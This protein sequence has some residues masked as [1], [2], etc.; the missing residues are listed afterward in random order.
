MIPL[1]R[2]YLRG[3]QC[4]SNLDSRIGAVRSKTPALQ[5]WAI[6][7]L[8]WVINYGIFQLGALLFIC[9]SPDNLNLYYSSFTFG[10]APQFTLLSASPLALLQYPESVPMSIPRHSKGPSKSQQRP[11]KGQGYKNR[12]FLSLSSLCP[13][14]PSQAMNIVHV[15]GGSVGEPIFPSPASV[16]GTQIQLR[17]PLCVHTVCLV[18]RRCQM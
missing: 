4:K 7:I 5:R 10:S 1:T 15:E 8:S 17:L 14:Y 16:K 3:H 9:Y 18:L 12:G 6:L 2:S 13:V 11:R